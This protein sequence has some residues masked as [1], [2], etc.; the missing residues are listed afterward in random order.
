MSYG[1]DTIRGFVYDKTGRVPG[2]MVTELGSE[3]KLR[4]NEKGEFEIRTQTNDPTLTFVF[5]GFD[6]KTIKIR[7]RKF[8]KIKLKW[9][10]RSP[11]IAILL[12][13]DNDNQW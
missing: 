2:V 13:R 1:Q 5:T 12:T 10:K 7:K 6:T 8:L 11:D 3:N 9:T 4:T